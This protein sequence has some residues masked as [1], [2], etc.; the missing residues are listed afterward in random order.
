MKMLV[1][2]PLAGAFTQQKEV[3]VEKMIFVDE[4]LLALHRPAKGSR[5]EHS[6]WFVSDMASGIRVSQSISADLA[7]KMATK[8]VKSNKKYFLYARKKILRMAA[9][10]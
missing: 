5:D 7:M 8:Q 4:F 2:V 3:K 9:F 1:G 10:V 6:L